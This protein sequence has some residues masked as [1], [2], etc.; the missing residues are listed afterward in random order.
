MIYPAAARPC[1]PV[2]F[3]F[4]EQVKEALQMSQMDRLP[5][6]MVPGEQGVELLQA[7]PVSGRPPYREPDGLSGPRILCL[8]HARLL[9]RLSVEN[10]RSEGLEE[11]TKLYDEGYHICATYYAQRRNGE[12]CLFCQSFLK[13]NL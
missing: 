1:L 10:I 13:E 5:R 6:H 8:Y 11:L 2:P 4:R 7:G 9:E 12:E 3:S